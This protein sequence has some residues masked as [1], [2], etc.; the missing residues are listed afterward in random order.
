ML[1]LAENGTEP[2]TLKTEHGQVL[3]VR[4]HVASLDEV[5]LLSLRDV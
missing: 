5:E 1:F 2:K 3:S 4:L